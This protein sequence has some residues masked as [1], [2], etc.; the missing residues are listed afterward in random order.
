MFE[1]FEKKVVHLHRIRVWKISLFLV[2]K[3]AVHNF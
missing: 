3:D 2:K 1:E